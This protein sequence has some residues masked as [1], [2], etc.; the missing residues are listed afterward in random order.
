MTSE[1][2]LFPADIIEEINGSIVQHGPHNDRVYLMRFKQAGET[3]LL[4]AELDTLARKNQYGKI[5]AKIPA[6]EWPLFKASGF[7]REAVVPGFFYGRVDGLFVSKY[8]SESRSRA[9]I[10]A[11]L[12]QLLSSGRTAPRNRPD[13]CREGTITVDSCSGNDA[14]E[15]SAVYREVFSSYPFPVQNHDYLKK[16]MHE[17][18]HYFCVRDEGSIAALAAAEID[19]EYK[20]AELTDFAT[21]PR[22]RKR[23]F[24]GILLN[25]M[26]QTIKRAG[27]L[28]AFTIARAV[29]MGMNGVFKKG[30]YSFSGFLKNNT[31]IGSGI[32]NMTVWHKHL[33]RG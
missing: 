21:L 4:L 24:A 32:E 29:S 7:C 16:M 20:N 23:G 2:S 18:V 5:F 10:N 19:P 14:E 9:K 17:E 1:A 12:M 25:H 13:P 33:D 27:I 22:W 28:T 11:E 26:E 15:M 6:P 8:F 3:Q 30:G 31:N